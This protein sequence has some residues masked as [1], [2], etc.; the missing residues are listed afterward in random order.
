MKRLLARAVLYLYAQTFNATGYGGYAVGRA[1][2]PPKSLKGTMPTEDP[3]KTLEQFRAS[4]GRLCLLTCQALANG[5][6]RVNVHRAFS[7]DVT[8]PFTTILAAYAVCDARLK[9]AQPHGETAIVN[10]A[11][12]VRKAI[13]GE[14]MVEID[15]RV[16]VGP[17]GHGG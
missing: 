1:V 14:W 2:K 3:T 13:E 15:G 10:T 16:G 4:Y 11:Q 5:A 12:D 7:G 8:S 6:D 17:G 9:A